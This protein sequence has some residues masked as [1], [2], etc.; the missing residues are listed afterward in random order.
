VTTAANGQEALGIL[1]EL[2]PAVLI[3]D[4]MME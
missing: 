4:V 1:H 2:T 3:L